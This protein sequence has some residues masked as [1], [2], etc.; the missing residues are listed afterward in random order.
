[1]TTV[2]YGN[3]SPVTMGGRALVGALGWLSIIAFGAITILSSNNW[4]AIV[5]DL[6]VYRMNKMAWVS[7]PAFAVPVWGLIGCGWI[8][9]IASR[10]QDYWSERIPGFEATTA[11]SIWFG[12]ITTL[13]GKRELRSSW[14]A[15]K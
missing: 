5:D 8:L 6:F 12:Y 15:T 9:H 3:Q 11:D 1:M 4:T 13:T 14:L 10:A 7:R 2:G